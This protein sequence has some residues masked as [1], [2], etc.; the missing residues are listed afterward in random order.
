VPS[1]TVQE[2]LRSVDRTKPLGLRDYAI[3]LLVTTYGLRASEAALKLDDIE[4][5]PGRILVPQLRTAA[6]LVLPLT[7][8]VGQAFVDHPARGASLAAAP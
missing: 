2:F 8:A 1:G 4:W 7:D 5:R 3:F 6:R